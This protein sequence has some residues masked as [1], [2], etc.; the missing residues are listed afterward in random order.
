MC[1]AGEHPRNRPLSRS[2]AAV[3]V[4]Q[5]LFGL[6]TQASRQA[7]ECKADKKFHQ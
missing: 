3:V 4:A 2:C 1:L 5:I 7:N 6:R